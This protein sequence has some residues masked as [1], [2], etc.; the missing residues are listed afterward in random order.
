M[1]DFE[2]SIKYSLTSKNKFI[3]H[4]F[5]YDKTGDKLYEELMQN[6]KYYLAKKEIEIIA[7]NKELILNSI[8]KNQENFNLIDLG[9]GSGE[10]TEILI[11]YFLSKNANFTYLPVDF[12]KNSL[13]KLKKKLMGNYPKLQ[14]NPINDDY[15]KALSLINKKYKGQKIIV[16]FGGNI[17]N[18]K[19]E[20]R[21]TFFKK[22]NN[23]LN[24]N[25]LIIN[26]FD[27]I[28]NPKIIVNAYNSNLFSKCQA[29]IIDILNKKL[30]LNINKDNFEYFSSYNPI[31]GMVDFNI[32]SK[33]KQNIYI[34][35]IDF[36][37][38]LRQ[39]EVI[40]C[41]HSK[42]FTM[43][44][45]EELANISGFKIKETL[46]DKEKYYAN[47]IWQIEKK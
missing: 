38:K 34:K 44:V 20:N 33:I 39:W 30:E 12:S 22:L 21:I 8:N 25:D 46:L 3:D 14:I 17:G 6:D 10:K 36:I 1:T 41:G 37:L 35:K 5:T 26:G 16:F 24:I 2:K 42:K 45:I 27:L 31:S 7:N 40:N 28:K 23:V 13:D 9:S 29:N 43:Q 15:F 11:N 4:K 32:I 18:L 47:S 19:N